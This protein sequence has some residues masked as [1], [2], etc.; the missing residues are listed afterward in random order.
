MN[1]H[2]TNPQVAFR[3]PRTLIKRLDRLSKAL[4]R[5]EG[6]PARRSVVIRRAVLAGLP[7]L[8]DEALSLL[9]DE[10]GRHPSADEAT[11]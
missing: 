9:T 4:Q 3:A 5:S 6:I 1:E 2:E 8:E 7:Q 11:S 10:L